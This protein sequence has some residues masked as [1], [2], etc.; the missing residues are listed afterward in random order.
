MDKQDLAGRKFVKSIASDNVSPDATMEGLSWEVVKL[1]A[2]HQAKLEKLFT[3]VKC[4]DNLARL[5]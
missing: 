2:D 3:T 5:L 1:L 4:K